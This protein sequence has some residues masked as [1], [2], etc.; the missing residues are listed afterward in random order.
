MKSIIITIGILLI[1]CASVCLQAEAH[2]FYASFVTINYNEQEKNV[3]ITIRAFP[4]DLEAALSKLN[5]KSV[6]LDESKETGVMVM[7]YLKKTFEIKKNNRPQQLQWVGMEVKV[8]SAWIYI[9]AK[10]PGGLSG[11]QLRDQF[12]F[13]MFNDQT[14]V[15]SLKYKGKQV[16]HVFRGNDGFKPLP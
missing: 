14:N 15:V 9:E 3:E 16:D 8:D 10:M 6:K 13:D 11:A 12:L 1:L 4:D 5:N 7:A 2:K